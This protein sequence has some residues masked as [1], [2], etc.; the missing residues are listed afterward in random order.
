MKS[1]SRNQA[2]IT[3]ATHLSSV[4]IIVGSLGHGFKIPF[5][6]TALSFYQLYI[7]LGLII[8][9]KTKSISVFNV[10]V[11]VA[12]MKTLSPFGK[13][14]TPM[15]AIT[16]QGF[17]LWLGTSLL[18]DSLAGMAV[19]SVLFVSWSLVQTAIGYVLLYGFDFFKMLIFLQKEIGEISGVNIYFILGGYWVLRILGA[20]TMIIYLVGNQTSG[21]VWTID[22]ALLGRW[23]SRMVKKSTELSVSIWKQSL[24]DLL[25]PFFFVS[26]ILMVCFH[27]YRESSLVEII[28]FMSRTIAIGFALFYLIRDDWT[29]RRLIGI[30]GRNKKFRELYRMTYRVKNNFRK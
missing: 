13:K 22:E 23:Q 16:V 28:W 1:D 6:G 30:F 2:E 3:A 14:I 9:S 10:S 17:L 8:R 12:L 29:R 27:F 18:G 15:M 20:F 7:C 24:R 4:E 5:T 26:F 19:G 11:V 21:A 25:N